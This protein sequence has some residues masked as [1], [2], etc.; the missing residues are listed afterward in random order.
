MKQI[1]KEIRKRLLELQDVEYKNFQ[2][3]LIPTLDKE[4]IIGIRTPILR[5]FANSLDSEISNDY[6][7]ILPHKYFEEYN[8][9]C[10][11]VEKIKNYDECIL[12][13]KKIL[14]YI[15]N[16]ATCDTFSPKIFKKNLNDLLIE[17]KKWI[18]SDKPYIV[19]FGIGMLM[20]YFLDENF[21]MEYLDM[22]A[23][24]KFKSRY[25]YKKISITECEDK[26]YVEMMISWFFATALSK[27]Y[28][29]AIKYLENQS[30]CTFT[31]N[32]IIKK[33]RESFRISQDRK[34]KISKYYI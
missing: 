20:R 32:M 8:L 19:R 6:I 7:K 22:V 10:F 25:K 9:H 28:K 24:I 27:Q 21:K 4:K 33:S 23:K 14:P 18:K 31:N 5:N 12:H 26:Y 30:F 3:K 2:S 29:Y 1:E 11:I 15:D 34:N 17:I 16:W 13:T